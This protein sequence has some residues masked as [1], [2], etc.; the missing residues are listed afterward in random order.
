MDSKVIPILDFYESLSM[1]TKVHGVI[2][3]AFDHLEEHL[4]PENGLAFSCLMRAVFLEARVTFKIVKGEVSDYLKSKVPG[5]I[6]DGSIFDHPDKLMFLVKEM[7]AHTAVEKLLL[8][9]PRV[10]GH[11]DLHS[12][13]N[14]K[15]PHER[16]PPVTQKTEPGTTRITDDEMV[17]SQI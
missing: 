6:D 8:A 10:M 13:G 5:N 7:K 17:Q 14:F 11:L 9:D 16:E 3:S 2:T 12:I 15:F 4:K 1:L